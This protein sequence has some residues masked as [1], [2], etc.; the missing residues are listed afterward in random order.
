MGI[1]VP[2]SYQSR[3]FAFGGTGDSGESE[4]KSTERVFR[5]VRRAR[6]TAR[7][8]RER[9]GGALEQE[10]EGKYK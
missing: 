9:G 5:G 3:G 1:A 7:R 2:I 6:H 10:M 4:M 8:K